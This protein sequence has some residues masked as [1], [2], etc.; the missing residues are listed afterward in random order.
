MSDKM[1]IMQAINMA[2]RDALAADDNVILFG[3]DVADPEGGGVFTITKGLSSE[4][5]DRVRST[6]ISEQGFVGAGVGAAIAGMRPV[7]EVMMMNFLSVCMDQVVNHA[8]KIRFMS[9]GQTAVPLTIRTM[10][11]AGFQ[12]GGQHSDWTEAWFAHT[13]GMKVVMPSNP[14]DAYGLMRSCIDDDDPCLVLEHMAL[15]AAQGPAPEPG[16]K[17][18]LGKAN[19]VQA[20]SD[21][22]LI[23][24]GRGVG[25][26][27]AVAAELD[28]EGIKAEVIDLR[29]ISPLD[30]ETIFASVAKT[31]RAVV[32]H[33]AVRSFGV[34]AEI[35][36]R[37]HEQ[38]FSDLKAPVQRVASS[39]SPVPFAAPLETAFLYSQAE[40]AEA[41][42]KILN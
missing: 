6:P 24:Y 42:K 1:M 35:S 10:S 12:T 29:T 31:G 25:D 9:G 26:C 3:E 22:S 13:P 11:G 15:Y 20:G 19:I 5:G 32:V 23:T 8:A 17:V 28:K 40:I 38:L 30:D 36:S 37:I 18:P 41:A 7:V 33:E 21:V 2:L 27:L 34:G 16:H 4:F 14:A 39:D